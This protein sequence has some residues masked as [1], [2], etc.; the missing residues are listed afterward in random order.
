MLGPPVCLDCKVVYSHDKYFD[1]Q[2]NVCVKW[3]CPVC[4]KSDT[5][6]Y[7]LTISKELFEELFPR[8]QNG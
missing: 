6:H 5:K 4:L 1:E 2:G 7:A 8:S 3:H